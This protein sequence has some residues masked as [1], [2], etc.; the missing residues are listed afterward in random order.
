MKGTLLSLFFCLI[1][2]FGFSQIELQPNPSNINS[3]TF[4]FKY[5]ELGD[6]SIFDPLG[7]PNLYLYTGLQTDA[8]P[9]TWDYN[10]GEFTLANLGQMIP[11]TYDNGLG[12]YVATFNPKTR[13]YIEEVSQNLVTVPNGTQVNDWYFL[14]TT[15]DLSRQS[16]DLKGTD[17]GFNASTLSVNGFSVGDDIIVLNGS[18]KFSKQGT[19]KIKVYNILGKL[20]RDK[21]FIITSSLTHDLKLEKHGIYIVKITSGQTTK[22]VKLLRH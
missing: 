21:S 7:N 2:A 8:D 9:I 20:I 6:Y 11:L 14:I 4:T 17:Y 22:T 12:Y 16:I 15:N 5:G 19:Y 1:T 3:G 10:D 13:Q 18:L